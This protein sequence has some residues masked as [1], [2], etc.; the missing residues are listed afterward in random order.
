MHSSPSLNIVEHC[1]DC[2]LRDHLMI[3][4]MFKIAG[5]LTSMVF[6]IAARSVATHALSTF[7]D[8][9]DVMATRSTGWAMLFANSIQEVMDFALIAQA[10]TLESRLP[11]ILDS[12]QPTIAL[13]DYIYTEGRYRML[14]KSGPAAKYLLGQAERAVRERLKH[15]GR[16]A[17]MKGGE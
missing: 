11:F 2:K 6:H 12:K 16:M 9:S 8:H 3:P 1:L 13:K 4:N 17:E 14:Q 15:Y 5:E 7:G 10:S